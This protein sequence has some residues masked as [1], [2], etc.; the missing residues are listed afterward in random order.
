MLLRRIDPLLLES[1]LKARTVE[2]FEDIHS[3]RRI[4]SPSFT[5]N[6]PIYICYHHERLKVW[7]RDNW[8][9]RYSKF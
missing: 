3:A 8:M 7:S 2:H 6:Y 1:Q 9:S 4:V 5:H